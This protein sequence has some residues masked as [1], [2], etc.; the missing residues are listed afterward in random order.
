MPGVARLVL[1]V[2]LVRGTQSPTEARLGLLVQVT[3]LRTQ[4]V[5][6]GFELSARLKK[7][8]ALG[9]QRGHRFRAPFLDLAGR[10]G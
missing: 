7:F 9:H 5:D 6:D 8:Q 1:T 4:V 2:C 10:A 3:D